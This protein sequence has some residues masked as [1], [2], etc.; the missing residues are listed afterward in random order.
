MSDRAWQNP[1]HGVLLHQGRFTVVR[2]RTA[3][4]ASAIAA[5]G[6]AIAGH[7]AHPAQ[8]VLAVAAACSFLALLRA[9]RRPSAA[10]WFVVRA[11]LAGDLA[12]FGISEANQLGTPVAAFAVISGVALASTATYTYTRRHR[13]RRTGR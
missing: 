2:V 6:L 4:I 7:A 12:L 11:L 1:N 9:R 3:A 5:A 10:D 13:K 8:V